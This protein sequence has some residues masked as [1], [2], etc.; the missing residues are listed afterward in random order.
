MLRDRYDPQDLF[1]QIPA[2]GLRLDPVLTQLDRL[3]EDDALFASVREA[4]ARRHPHTLTRGRPSTPVEVLL[5]LLV[6]KR[7]YN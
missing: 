2:H 7:L 1:T 3:L 4:L 5:R 6:V